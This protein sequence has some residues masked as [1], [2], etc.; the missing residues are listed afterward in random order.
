M[1]Q[2]KVE[3][4][5]MALALCGTRRITAFDNPSREARTCSDNYELCRRALLRKHPWN[6]ATKRIILDTVSADP[7]AFGYENAFPLPDDFIRVH[8]VYSGG[9]LIDEAMY[10]VESARLLTDRDELWL[11]YIWDLDDTR[12][13]D[14][15]F[16]R[17]LAASLAETISP[18]LTAS[19]ASLEEIHRQLKDAERAARFVDSVED[20]SRELDADVWLQSRLGVSPGFVRDPMT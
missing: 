17:Y 3:L 13:F 14:P 18:I 9:I 6:F 7:P 16:D 11:K 10:R 15:L 1:V 12:L 19:S 2:D 5:N 8:T 20:P 4:A